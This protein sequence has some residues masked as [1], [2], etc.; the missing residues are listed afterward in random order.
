MVAALVEVGVPDIS[1]VVA[2]ID[3]PAGNEGVVVQP[4][5]VPAV[6]VGVMLVI[7]LFEIYLY[8]VAAKVISGLA[9]ASCTQTTAG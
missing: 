4:V 5:N 7:A 9:A 1:H 8:V 3:S 2:L 6:R